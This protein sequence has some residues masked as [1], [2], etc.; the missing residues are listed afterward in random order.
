MRFWTYT[1]HTPL[2]SDRNYEH[3]RTIIFDEEYVSL[4]GALHV[5]LVD[6]ICRFFTEVPKHV[7]YSISDYSHNL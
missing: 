4:L 5:I 3:Y 1:F 7:N 6:A 2:I